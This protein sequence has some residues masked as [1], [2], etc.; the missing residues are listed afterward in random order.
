MRKALRLSICIQCISLLL[1]LGES[2]QRFFH[3]GL[4]LSSLSFSGPSEMPG[5]PSFCGRLSL[6]TKKKKKKLSQM[7]RR[8]VSFLLHHEELLR[9]LS[10]QLCFS[11]T[12]PAT[13]HTFSQITLVFRQHLKSTRIFK[14]RPRLVGLKDFFYSFFKNYH[15]QSFHYLVF[16]EPHLSILLLANRYAN[17]VRTIRRWTLIRRWT[18]MNPFHSS[19]MIYLDRHHQFLIWK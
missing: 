14:F 11:E 12:S 2:V 1:Q 8:T 9:A 16:Q 5:L 19:H 3:R 17:G 15:P 13:D 18:M 10:S 6:H 4:L 7:L